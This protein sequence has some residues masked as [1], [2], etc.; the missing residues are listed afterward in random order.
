MNT[1]AAL[2]VL[3]KSPQF[4]AGSR[5]G[6]GTAANIFRPS[7]ETAPLIQKDFD[8]GRADRRTFTWRLQNKHVR[9]LRGRDEEEGVVV[10]GVGW[11]KQCQVGD[12]RWL[13]FV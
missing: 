11:G 3:E 5:S 1:K 8:P 13:S 7:S 9:S 4:T 2:P 6:A 10:E 12:Y